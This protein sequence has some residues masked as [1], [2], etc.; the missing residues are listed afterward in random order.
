[1]N[2][3][4]VYF[5]DKKKK[6]T[7]VSTVSRVGAAFPVTQPG[8]RVC[9]QTV[10]LFRVQ[11]EFCSGTFVKT[12]PKER[13]RVLGSAMSNTGFPQGQPG[14]KKKNKQQNMTRAGEDNP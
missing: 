12:L 2:S 8:S 7:P 14:K 13:P 10:E 3:G 9:C 5:H 1:M 6:N 11:L 4:K